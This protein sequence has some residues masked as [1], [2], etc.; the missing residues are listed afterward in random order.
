MQNEGS[1][2]SYV[3]YKIFLHVSIQSIFIGANSPGLRQDLF[4]DKLTGSGQK[5]KEKRGERTFGVCLRV[6]FRMPTA[7][8]LYL[9]LL[10]RTGAWEFRSLVSV[11]QEVY[12]NL[13]FFALKPFPVL[14]PADQ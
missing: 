3:D 12:M 2:N 1:W 13:T 5:G 7:S 14:L 8:F 6:A 4:V 11:M 9:E 10:V